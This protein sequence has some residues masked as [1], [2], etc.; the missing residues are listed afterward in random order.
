[1]PE[2]FFVSWA[3]LAGGGGSELRWGVASVQG[4]F[5]PASALFYRPIMCCEIGV[6]SG[7]SYNQSMKLTWYS[8]RLRRAPSQATYAHRY[9]QE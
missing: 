4:W 7:G 1:M 8:A 3:G 5:R 6:F 9:M 2:V